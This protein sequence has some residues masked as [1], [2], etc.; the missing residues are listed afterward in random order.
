[1]KLGASGW[2]ALAAAPTFAL[3]ALVMVLAGD[4]HAAP[5]CSQGGGPPMLTGM[6]PMYLLMTAFHLPAWLRLTSG[7]GSS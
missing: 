2:L 3:M 1:M 7:A 6:A 4:G 5:L